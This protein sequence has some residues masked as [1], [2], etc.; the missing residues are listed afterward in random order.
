MRAFVFT[1]PALSS[2]AGRFVWLAV[3][4]EVD[5][6]ATT[7]Q[8]LALDAWP[9]FYVL[10]PADERVVLRWVGSMTVEQVVGFLDD[11][12]VALR[13]GTPPSQ[14][15]RLLAGADRLYAEGENARAAAAYREALDVAPAD[16]PAY[17]RAV[18]ALLF[19]YAVTD[20]DESCVELARE[21]LPRLRHTAHAISVSAS[22]LDCTLGLPASP[23]RD[24]TRADW[25]TAVREALADPGVDASAD[26][27]SGAWQTLV[28]AREDA[29]DAAG[30][31]AAAE[32]WAAF[33]EAQ[34]AAAATPEQRA[35]FD[36]HRLSAYLEL[37]EPERAIPMLEASE[38]AL[39]G[40]Y[41]PPARLALAWKAM[42]RWDEALAASDRALDLAYGPRR[43]GLLLNR[44]DILVAK[45]A[46]E[47]SVKVLREALAAVE[48]LPE[49][50]R[51]ERLK[52]RV[53]DR[54]EAATSEKAPVAR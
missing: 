24:A 17:G 31:R 50:E 6:N 47:A 40:D 54:L 39:P 30:A 45:G 4:T 27:R 25:E 21:A 2:L 13:G 34:A 20:A 5:T 29:G 8:R 28:R 37:G 3:N 16:W 26:D 9:S 22:G 14:S 36:S 41:N 51:T 18:E 1:D 35:V 33:L 44:A 10:D 42:G 15:D 49:G 11:A 32:T 12:R 38:R 7:V 23:S 52:K 48:A 46:P 43:V 53:E 19:A